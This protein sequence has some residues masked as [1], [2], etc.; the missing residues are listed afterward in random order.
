MDEADQ[1]WTRPIVPLND[2]GA[3][4]PQETTFQDR[5]GRSAWIAAQARQLLSSYRRD[6]F[7]DPDCYLLQVGAVLERYEDAII[8]Y[9]T[10][11]HT[12]IQRHCQW[13][14][15]IAEVVS[16]CDAEVS[17][18]QRLATYTAMGTVRPAAY[19]GPSDFKQFEALTAKYGRP[20]GPFETQGDRWNRDKQPPQ[21]R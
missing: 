4:Q 6:D 14:P 7:A 21:A 20:V 1:L 2:S 12:G 17:R 19:L 10:H 16:Y 15:S 13:S 8:G 11:P 5:A 3:P 9:A 18:K